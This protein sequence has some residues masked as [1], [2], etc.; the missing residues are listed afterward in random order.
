MSTSIAA[1]MTQRDVELNPSPEPALA[2]KAASSS[3]DSHGVA[4]LRIFPAEQSADSESAKSNKRALIAALAIAG[5]L[6]AIGFLLLVF[7]LI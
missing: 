3:C 7:A 4:I 1:R 5:F 6:F 2:P